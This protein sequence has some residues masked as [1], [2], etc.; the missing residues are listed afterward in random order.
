MRF[1]LHLIAVPVATLLV[2]CGGGGDGG[3]T[4]PPSGGSPNTPSTP[5]TPSTPAAPVQ[6]SS[7]QIGNNFFSP[8]DVQVSPG[9]TVTWTWPSGV[10]IHNVSFDDGQASGNKS[11]GG[12]YSR[13]FNT[14]GTF[15]Y[16]CTLHGGMNGSVL[17]K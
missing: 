10:D 11:A 3:T 4:A 16:Q 8:A 12:S 1:R 7:V 5:S 17:V 15:K 2:A 13:T 6:T 9:T 14:T